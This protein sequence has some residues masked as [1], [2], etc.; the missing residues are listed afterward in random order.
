MGIRGSPDF[1]PQ[2]KVFS[3][4][5]SRD[6]QDYC[7]R[8]RVR[9]SA[10]CSRH[11]YSC[12]FESMKFIPHANFQEAL[13]MR[14][15]LAN[16]MLQ[17]AH[18]KQ[19]TYMDA[20]TF[21]LKEDMPLEDVFG[22]HAK[23]HDFPCTVMLQADPYLI[24]SG[25]FSVTNTHW[26]R[27]VFLPLWLSIKNEW[28]RQRVGKWMTEPDQKSL[29]AAVLRVAVDAMGSNYKNEAR[30]GR[31]LKNRGKSIRRKSKTTSS[32]PSVGRSTF[33]G[34]LDTFCR[35]EVVD[36]GS[37]QWE[38]MVKTVSSWVERKGR[39]FPPRAYWQEPKQ[40]SY[41]EML[42]RHPEKI[43]TS[44]PY[45]CFN[46]AMQE[47]LGKTTNFDYSFQVSETD[48]VCFMGFDGPQANRQHF[49]TGSIL[50]QVPDL[51]DTNHKGPLLRHGPWKYGSA[52]SPDL[53][54]THAHLE[55]FDDCFCVPD[56]T[57]RRSCSLRGGA[58]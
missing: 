49:I 45:H 52:Y 3:F 14:I 12:T 10:Y 2:H 44:I 41:V 19:L 21:I 35:L 17:S 57:Q 58:N 40:T 56:R 34:Q 6:G 26:V 30:S 5:G 15:Y 37:L 27:T 50:K 18:V 33:E 11:G 1:K 51:N 39:S 9:R 13:A 16:Q 29:V 43:N 4:Y 42:Q 46:Y 53:L 22:Y 23:K 32:P 48:G 47:L 24:N 38:H 8:Y 31:E 20:D 25:F 28:D 55:K 7:P 54:M 36:A